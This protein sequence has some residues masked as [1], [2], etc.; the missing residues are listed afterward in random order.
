MMPAEGT[1]A[2]TDAALALFAWGGVRWLQRW[3][4]PSLL[5]STWLA[6]IGTFGVA[7][8]LGALAHGLD[9]SDGMRELL[10]QPLYLS[11]GV[12]VALFVMAAI[13]AAW[14]DQAARRA[15]PALLVAALAFY[16]LTRVSGGDFLV[17][18]IYEGAGLLFALGVHARLAAAGRA[19]A[20]WVAAGL[21]VSLAAGAV[22][23]ADT[24]T[25]RLVWTFDHNGIYH[26]VQAVGLA[27]LLLGLRRLLDDIRLSA[28]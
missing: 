17:F 12:A 7:A 27:L 19:G 23:A 9:W 14:G 10:W 21:A 20:G 26:L 11:L 8:L 18:V 16:V 1:T 5:R 25:L 15:R 28:S 24:L 2:A 6:A 3:T 22:Q 13:G 4:P